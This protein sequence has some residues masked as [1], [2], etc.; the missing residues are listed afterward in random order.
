[1]ASLI[2][3]AATVKMMALL[4]AMPAT[5]RTF[6]KESEFKYAIDSKSKEP[7]A[8][9]TAF[10]SQAVDTERIPGSPQSYYT[11]DTEFEN[12][13]PPNLSWEMTEPDVFK[14]MLASET[15]A[16]GERADKKSEEK[17]CSSVLINDNELFKMSIPTANEIK[18]AMTI[19]PNEHTFTVRCYTVKDN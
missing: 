5:L 16:C 15:D 1:M 4:S 10:S 6:L 18:L 2:N 13:K 14:K 3:T 8:V 9:S 12:I 7:P 17:P 19:R 11:C